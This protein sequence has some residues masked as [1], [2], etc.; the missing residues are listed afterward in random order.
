LI[1]LLVVIA[2]IAILA[3]MLLPA[4]SHAKET[5]RQ[6]NCANNLRQLALGVALYEEDYGDRFPNCYDGSVGNGPSGTNGWTFFIAFGLPTLHF[7]PQY[8]A[9]FPFVGN[10]NVFVC[11]SDRAYLGQSYAINSLLER[12]TDVTG[13]HEGISSSEV[14]ATS[15]TFLFLEE[16]AP[17]AAGSTDDGY[18]DPRNN[19]ISGRHRGGSNC[20]FCDSHVAWFRT[21]A[22][23][24]PN[25]GASARFEP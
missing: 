17:K 9:L 1:E 3:A 6:T 23:K 15:A 7:E 20:A 5:A 14:A 24:Y 11:L 2:I 13:F 19:H 4:L 12:G 18:F 16:A 25:P 8:G 22:V 21:N 10:T